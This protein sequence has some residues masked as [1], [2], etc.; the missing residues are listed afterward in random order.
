MQ[1]TLESIL[2][3][4]GVETFRNACV[5][6]LRTYALFE[7]C[8]NKLSSQENLAQENLGF[9]EI[10]VPE[11]NNKPIINHRRDVLEQ[12]KRKVFY[13]NSGVV[14]YQTEIGSGAIKGRVLQEKEDVESIRGEE[15]RLLRSLSVPELLGKMQGIIDRIAAH[16]HANMLEK[17][18]VN[19]HSS[20]YDIESGGKEILKSCLNDVEK[21]LALPGL[22]QSDRNELTVLNLALESRCDDKALDYRD[23]SIQIEE[24]SALK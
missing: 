17:M 14:L 20:G 10:D 24:L 19:T 2:D 22:E 7:L 21:S 15:S 16:P 3:S 13:H 1:N 4:D 5:R 6:E 8:L 12:L 9:Q 23:L 11:I 18:L